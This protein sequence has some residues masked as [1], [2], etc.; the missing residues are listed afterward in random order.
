MTSDSPIK[1]E[2][3]AKLLNVDTDYL[4]K[5]AA[6]YELQISLSA[7]GWTGMWVP[8]NKR[9]AFTSRKRK[10]KPHKLTTKFL[11]YIQYDHLNTYQEGD[12][13]IHEWG[14][15]SRWEPECDSYKAI[16]FEKLEEYEAI[17]T[18]YLHEDD[19]KR[20]L[21]SKAKQITITKLRSSDDE[22]YNPEQRS[23]YGY[24]EIN[25]ST[26]IALVNFK[27]LFILKDN[28][29]KISCSNITNY[30]GFSLGTARKIMEHL[31]IAHKKKNIE[32]PTNNS[33]SNPKSFLEVFNLINSYC[34]SVADSLPE[35]YQDKNSLPKVGFCDDKGTSGIT[36][37][38]IADT[39]LKLS[40]RRTEDY[41]KKAL[42]IN[43]E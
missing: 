19:A 28:L 9:T 20:L 14:F 7:P 37:L 3:A 11:P 22:N 13:T 41:L 27:D 5:K 36:G 35:D 30:D 15:G 33:D 2:R 25:K 12:V 32:L 23:K 6:N 17:G 16:D 34:H 31:I 40:S 1:I 43:C 18:F 8:E 38:L 29:K 39:K 42:Q 21:N 4:L 10:N 24:F 26:N